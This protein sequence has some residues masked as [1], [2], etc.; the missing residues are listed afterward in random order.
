MKK[1]ELMKQVRTSIVGILGC[2]SFI[3]MVGEPI[4]EE[5]WFQVFCITKCF[6]FLIGY[7]CYALFMYWKSKGLL[8]TDEEV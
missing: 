7:M 6:A 8:P 5:T 4:K 3:L 1:S 2:I